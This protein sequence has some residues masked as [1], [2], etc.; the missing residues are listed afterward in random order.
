MS[1]VQSGGSSRPGSSYGNHRRTHS[2]RL[3]RSHGPSVG[4][5]MQPVHDPRMMQRHT[6]SGGSV[7]AAPP[8]PLPILR[9]ENA[10]RVYTNINFRI[11]RASPAFR[12]QF[13]RGQEVVGRQINDFVDPRHES[14]LHRLQSALRDEREKLDPMALPP[15]FS[16]QEQE[17]AEAVN[18]AELDRYLMGQEFS[19]SW[20]FSVP[21]IPPQTRQF[22]IRLGRSTLGPSS[23][24]FVLFSMP[25]F[26]PVSLPPPVPSFGAPQQQTLPGGIPPAPWEPQFS[27]RSPG[28]TSFGGYQPGS[29]PTTPSLSL[30]SLASSLPPSTSVPAYGLS[31]SS[32]A[33]FDPS[34][35]GYFPAQPRTRP[36]SDPTT[37]QRSPAMQY[38]HA[39]PVPPIPPNFPPPP[40]T[41]SSTTSGYSHRP[42]STASDPYGF[43]SSSRSSGSR[44]TT[45]HGRPRTYSTMSA[46]TPRSARDPMPAGASS[47]GVGGG[48][49]D[50]GEKRDDDE[51]DVR[52]RRRLNIKEITD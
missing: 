44:P 36:R 30:Q 15:I 50:Q 6:I 8:P 47:S 4:S 33:P 2:G 40:P 38:A 1:D 21:G 12:D 14:D 9:P 31:S 24:N 13:A 26:A 25:Y 18:E 5:M 3:L 16:Q 48:G 22:S 19:E 34:Q 27:Q 52:K 28:H 45:F 11:L 46:G 7:P 39:P 17:A 29:G 51:E 32:S 43:A 42:L 10:A 20:M 37:V 41:P 23:H 49:G 35:P